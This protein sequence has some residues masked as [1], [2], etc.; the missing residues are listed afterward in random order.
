MS[1]RDPSHANHQKS[2]LLL[3][4]MQTTRN[5]DIKAL[6]PPIILVNIILENH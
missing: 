2:N 1:P 3:V 6:A 4:P 5:C